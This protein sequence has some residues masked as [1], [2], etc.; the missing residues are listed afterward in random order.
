MHFKGK[1]SLEVMQHSV[2]LKCVR[3]SEYNHNYHPIFSAFSAAREHDRWN[4]TA[5]SSHEKKHQLIA[6]FFPTSLFVQLD[7]TLFTHFTQGDDQGASLEFVLIPRPCGLRICVCLSCHS[8]T[9]MV[10]GFLDMG[11][12]AAAW[13]NIVCV[14]GSAWYGCACTGMRTEC[15]VSLDN[16]GGFIS[17]DKTL[18]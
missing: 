6:L 8:G 3:N 2:L 1:F 10:W 4:R 18:Q 9:A 14:C 17:V 13:K 7:L 11:M 16:K 12:D 15:C 5:F